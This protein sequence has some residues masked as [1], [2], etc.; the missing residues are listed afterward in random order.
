M[1]EPLNNTINNLYLLI[2]LN[3]FFIIATYTDIRYMKIYNKFNLVMLITRIITFFI[4]GFNIQYLIGGILIFVVFL[5]GAIVT[6]AKIGGDIKFGGN[7]GLWVGF[8][9]SVFIILLTLVINLIFR[10][11]TKNTKPIA[12]A[13]F[14]YVSFIIVSLISYFL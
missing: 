4:W 2:I 9:P 1:L 12:L 3:I 11:I 14:L 8:M 10:K 6:K 7:I 5:G 13:P